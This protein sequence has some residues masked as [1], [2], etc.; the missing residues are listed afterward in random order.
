MNEHTWPERPCPPESTRMTGVSLSRQPPA[1]RCNDRE[2]SSDLPPNTATK[3]KN[4][5]RLDVHERQ[6]LSLNE[7]VGRW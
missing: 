5:R 3:T 2:D 6:K 4:E 7:W 1:K